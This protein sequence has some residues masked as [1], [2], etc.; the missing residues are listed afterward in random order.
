MTNVHL[1]RIGLSETKKKQNFLASKF[2]DL[3]LFLQPFKS[4]EFDSR[5]FL[6][7]WLNLKF[8]QKKKLFFQKLD[9][10]FLRDGSQ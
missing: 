10:V 4:F 1:K 7:L 6:S 5:F 3:F 9:A 8:S 2:I